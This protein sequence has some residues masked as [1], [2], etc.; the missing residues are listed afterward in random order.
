MPFYGLYIPVKGGGG[1][2]A[3]ASG[4]GTTNA[5]SNDNNETGK[6]CNKLH[7]AKIPVNNV[8]WLVN[9]ANILDEIGKIYCFF[10]FV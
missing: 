9:I 10:C 7:N 4:S 6:F 3:A 1:A 5:S 2:T 8:N